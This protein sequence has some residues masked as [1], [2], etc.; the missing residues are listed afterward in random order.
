MA[1]NR[2]HM[3]VTLEGE[4]SIVFPHSSRNN[5][6]ERRAREYLAS[7]KNQTIL[8]SVNSGAHQMEPPTPLIS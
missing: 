7:D 5:N 8:N 4:Q 3:K 1:V 6:T 2:G